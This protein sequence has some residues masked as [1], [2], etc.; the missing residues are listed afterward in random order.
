M[1][2]TI[3]KQLLKCDGNGKRKEHDDYKG[4]EEK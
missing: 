1:V 3:K 2:L 4:K